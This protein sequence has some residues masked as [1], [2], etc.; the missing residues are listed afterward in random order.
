MIERLD[1]GSRCPV[2]MDG[3]HCQHFYHEGL[4][5]HEGHAG[6]HCCY[7]DSEP[8]TDKEA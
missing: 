6:R 3:S 1:D 2:S 7:C 4:E 8:V 5:P